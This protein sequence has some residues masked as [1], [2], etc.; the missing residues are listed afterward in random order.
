MNGAGNDTLYGGGTADL[1]KGGIDNDDLRGSHGYNR[2]IAG[3][4]RD[5]LFGGARKDI[6]QGAADDGAAM[7]SFSMP[8]GTAPGG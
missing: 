7:F 3:D 2:L 4:G 8:S 1:L 5:T 6:L